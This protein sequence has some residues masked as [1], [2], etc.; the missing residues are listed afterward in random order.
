MVTKRAL[1]RF[2]KYFQ[3]NIENVSKNNQNAEEQFLL[4][5][6]SKEEISKFKFDTFSQIDF[7]EFGTY[8]PINSSIHSY[9]EFKSKSGLVS[10]IIIKENVDFKLDFYAHSDSVVLLECE[11]HK[12]AS[13]TINGN[14]SAKEGKNWI[15]IKLLHKDENSK[16][17]LNVLGYSSNSAECI[18]DGLVQ[19]G[20]KA[21]SSSGYQ[22]MKNFVLS[23]KAKV[24]SEPQLEIFNPHVECS[25]GCTISPIDLEVLYYLQSRG[26]SQEE[27]IRLLQESM[28]SGFLE[29]AG[30]SRDSEI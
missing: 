19:I 12:N 9:V 11:I 16:S 26:V 28:Y 25:H 6:V 5:A 4:S 27:S 15:Y 21:H 14:Y 24:F 22:T 10:K 8:I 23:N 18:N 7:F 3:E 29:R 20:R 2:E 1:N 17:D 13:C 30:K